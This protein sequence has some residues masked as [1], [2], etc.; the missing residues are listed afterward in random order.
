MKLSMLNNDSVSLGRN[1]KIFIFNK[2]TRITTDCDLAE[3]QT[4]FDLH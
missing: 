4:S 3:Q 2:A 1:L